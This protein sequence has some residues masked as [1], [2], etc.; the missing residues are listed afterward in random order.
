MEQRS[1]KKHKAAR[2]KAIAPVT[3]AQIRALVAEGLASGAARPVT[4]EYRAIKRR[5]LNV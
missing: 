1:I 2:G 3:A 5:K 4:P